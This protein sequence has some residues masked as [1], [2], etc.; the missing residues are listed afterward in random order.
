MRTDTF[1]TSRKKSKF[2]KM[3]RESKLAKSIELKEYFNEYPY[4]W[5]H[6]PCKTFLRV[7]LSIA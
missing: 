5:A 3:A 1:P 4:I 7:P 2:S 6:V